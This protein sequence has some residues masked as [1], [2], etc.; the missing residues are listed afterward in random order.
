MRGLENLQGLQGA[1]V[2]LADIHGQQRAIRFLKQILKK[3]AVPHAFLFS[4]MAGVGK[5]AAAMELAKALNCLNP[6][7]YDSCGELRLVP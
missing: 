1:E 4:G 6:Q 7:D 2:A 3:E 5:F